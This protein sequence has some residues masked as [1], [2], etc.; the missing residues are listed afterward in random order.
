MTPFRFIYPIVRLLLHSAIFRIN[1][2]VTTIWIWAAAGVLFDA[3]P[4]S[5]PFIQNY[6]KQ[7]YNASCQNWDIA[8]SGNHSLYSANNSGLL[9]FDGNNWTLYTLPNQ[10]VVNAVTVHNDTVFT[11]SLNDVGYWTS[12]INGSLTYHSLKEKLPVTLK[13]ETFSQLITQNGTL[14]MKSEHFLLQYRNGKIMLA[15]E[16]S[17]YARLLPDLTKLRLIE[18]N[19]SVWDISD[20][21][22]SENH[23]LQSASKL[24]AQKILTLHDDEYLICTPDEGIFISKNGQI[25]EWKPEWNKILKKAV[26]RDAVVTPDHIVIGTKFNGIYLFDKAGNLK[27]H[28]S[29]KTRLQDNFVHALALQNNGRLWAAFDNGIA[30]IDLHPAV[31]LLK[32]RSETGKLNSAAIMNGDIVLSTNQGYFKQTF[33]PNKGI[34]FQP[35]ASQSTEINENS[36][37]NIPPAIAD[38]MQPVKKWMYETDEIL[39]GIKEGNNVFRIRL[40]NNKTHAESIKTYGYYEGIATPSVS[41]I[42]VIDGVVV[43]ATG[44]NL[45]RYDKVSDRFI[46]YS[47][48]GKHSDLFC[49]ARVIFNA[50]N[51]HYWFCR[52]NE[53]GLFSIKDGES[54]LKCRILFDNY[55]LNLVN[56]EKRIIPLS[57]SLHLISTMEGTVMVNTRQLIRDNLPASASL[58]VNKIYYTATGQTYNVPLQ[59]KSFSLPHQFNS[60]NIQ[61]ATSLETP[62]HPISYKL[63]GVTS[64]WSPWQ[65][66]GKISFLQLPPGKYELSIR[67]Y[68]V[69]GPF[70]ETTLHI[71]VRPPWYAT[72]WATGIFIILIGSV[73]YLFSK[74]YLNLQKKRELSIRDAELADEKQKMQQ[75]RNEFL[76]KELRNKNN[77]LTLQTSGL[78]KKNQVMQSLLVELESQK[79]TL[80][81][82]YPNKLYQKLHRIIDENLNDQSDWTMFE[83]Y[84]NEAHQDFIERLR[85]QYPDLT[86]NDLRI[87]C[88][89]RMNLSTKEIASLLNVSIRAVELRRYRLRKRLLLENE[90]NLVSFLLNF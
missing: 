8:F 1:A 45:F 3:L 78:V 84:F 27:N 42:L 2:L 19:T 43:L 87:C 34:D 9:T 61:T 17:G 54:Q 22:L 77:E 80:G 26:I 32:E 13:N 36:V 21:S 75:L 11:G 81:D 55:D 39:W 4:Q 52:G 68:S 18:Q 74:H 10:S 24:E 28:L 60:L 51:N 90:E 64:Q 71:T 66:S 44:K 40:D 25:T 14:W 67:K 57:D 63:S 82:R 47:E 33:I 46:T 12:D 85:T 56:R 20:T 65:M 6:N 48:L 49:D 69:K 88:L 83:T 59:E 7:H 35:E 23:S 58:H 62:T 53:A 30:Q 37:P 72:F 31:S 70:P 16:F 41:D 50:D 15:K 73:I 38:S 5:I 89:L 76:E 86:T 29:F 79:E